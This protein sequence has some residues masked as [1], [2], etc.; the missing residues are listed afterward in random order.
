[1]P[2]IKN[3]SISFEK[4]QDLDGIANDK[5]VA[6]EPS[7][8]EACSVGSPPVPIDRPLPVISVSNC[9][10]DQVVFYEV[11]TPSRIEFEPIARLRAG[12]EALLEFLSGKQFGRSGNT[13]LVESA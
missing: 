9:P 4:H 3:V 13:T 2:D 8:L 5:V 7:H 12:K 6:S 11:G 1:M 10:R